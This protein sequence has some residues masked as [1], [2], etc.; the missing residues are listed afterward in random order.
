[1]KRKINPRYMPDN[2]KNDKFHNNK[3]FNKWR[4]VLE[5]LLPLGIALGLSWWMSA[6]GRD[7]AW[8]WA[9][10]DEESGEWARGEGSFWRFLYEFASVPVLVICGAAIVVL[11]ARYRWPVLRAWRRVSWYALA[12]LVVGP[13]L[14]TNLW[15][16][17]NWGRPRP[18]EITEFGGREPFEPVFGLDFT[19]IGKSFPCG[20][21]TMGFYFLGAFFLLRRRFPGWAWASLALSVGWGALIGYTRMLQGG[22]FATDVVWAAAVMWW[23][24]AILSAL[25]RFDR[26]VLD[27]RAP[28][29]EGG[30]GIPA[31]VK[32][33]GGLALVA[34]A[35]A[36]ALA[37]P[38]RAKREIHSSEPGSATAEAK[39]SIRV[40]SG[41]VE[42]VPGEELRITG[43][44]WGHGLPTSQIAERWEEA[45]EPD[46]IWRFKYLQRGSGY[47]TEIRQTLRI[48]VPWSRVEFLKLDLGPGSTV[49]R[50]PATAEPVK[51]ELVLRGT[52]LT[53]EADPEIPIRFETSGVGGARVTDQRGGE[54][55]SEGVHGYRFFSEGSQSGEVIIRLPTTP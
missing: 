32:V 1:M 35:T 26:G 25:F 2:Q 46:G 21:A 20:H 55:P 17:E 7:L 9:C 5:M 38:Y 37:T 4:F 18:R 50:L 51:I 27:Q 40:E 10:F 44:A 3:G 45:M 30:R 29:G 23:T 19:G 22:H 33:A 31:R 43:E 8:Q 39:G 52:E 53:L 13:G 28:D 24:A 54:I 15:L 12:L 48:T 11:V 49:M 36:L 16:K 14:I 6:T 42:I 47:F 41:E 34:L